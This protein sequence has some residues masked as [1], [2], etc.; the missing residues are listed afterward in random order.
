MVVFSWALLCAR[1][2]L[3]SQNYSTVNT[4]EVLKRADF[5]FSTEGT[6]HESDTVL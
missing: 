1:K 4:Y 5:G 2:N 3:L 6:V